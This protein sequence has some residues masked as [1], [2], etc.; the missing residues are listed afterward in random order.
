MSEAIKF[1]HYTG[2]GE[3]DR[4]F[5]ILDGLMTEVTFRCIDWW[6]GDDDWL[7]YEHGVFAPDVPEP[8]E[9]FTVR[10]DG[11]A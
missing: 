4:Y 10:I 7:Y 9:T 6:Y 11:R 1:A 5:T 2:D 3:T 8:I